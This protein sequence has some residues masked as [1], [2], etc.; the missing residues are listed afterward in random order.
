MRR[1]SLASAFIGIHWHSLAFI[2]VHWHWGG[3]HWHSLAFIGNVHWHWGGI[4]GKRSLAFIGIH[5]RSLASAFIDIETAFIGVRWK[6]W[7]AFIGVG[8][9]TFDASASGRFGLQEKE[10]GN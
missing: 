7:A 9:E 4:H 10:N 5:W 1:R 3:I 6:R 8:V 2:G